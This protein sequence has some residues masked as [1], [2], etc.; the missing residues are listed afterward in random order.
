[1]EDQLF[2]ISDAYTI[3]LVFLGYSKDIQIIKFRI[4]TD[5]KISIIVRDVIEAKLC[6]S[7]PFINLSGDIVRVHLKD[8]GVNNF[9]EDIKMEDDKITIKV[10]WR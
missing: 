3:K 9:L 6:Q 10:K 8:I 4:E 2:G 7:Y 5:P 1:M